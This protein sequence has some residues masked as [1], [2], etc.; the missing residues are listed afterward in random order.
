M[1]DNVYIHKTADVSK[2]AS[3]GANTKIWNW[4]QIRENASIGSDCI[5]SKGVYIDF[6]V[7]IGNKVKIQNN[8]SVY[9]GVTIKDGVF[10]GPHVCF[11]NDKNPR[12]ITHNGTLKS[13]KDWEL[14]KTTVK[15]GVSIGANATILPGIDIGEYAMIGSGTVVTKSVPDYSLVIG[16]P[17]K[18][19][20]YVCKCGKKF[21]NSDECR[22]CKIKLNEIK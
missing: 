18:I 4:A 1:K 10:I 19:V 16:N 9:H 13:D 17:G 5:I 15:K 3:I 21:D 6:G 20:G 12:A 2:D 14:Y 8:V 7:K 22:E 11:T